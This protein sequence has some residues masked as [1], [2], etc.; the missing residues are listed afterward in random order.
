MH[1]KGCRRKRLELTSFTWLWMEQR[2]EVAVCACVYFICLRLRRKK[3]ITEKT[4]SSI[5]LLTMFV[6]NETRENNKEYAFLSQSCAMTCAWMPPKSR[7]GMLS[8]LRL[9]YDLDFP[10]LL[11]SSYPVRKTR[12]ITSPKR[13]RKK[14]PQRQ[15]RRHSGA[16]ACLKPAAPLHTA[17][18]SLTVPSYRVAQCNQLLLQWNH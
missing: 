16:A 5:C 9:V 11:S 3:K 15:C 13:R 6:K 14:K 7:C 18:S 12:H 2:W 10:L 1:I 8:P 17:H 4:P